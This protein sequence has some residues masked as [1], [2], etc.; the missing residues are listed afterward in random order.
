MVM[1]IFV[2]VFDDDGDVCLMLI[3]T[4]EHFMND[5]TI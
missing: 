1:M 4:S 3:F 5:T 2:V